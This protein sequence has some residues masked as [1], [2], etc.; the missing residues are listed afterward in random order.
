MTTPK[1]IENE[2]PFVNNSNEFI[3]ILAMEI[4]GSSQ[5]WLTSPSGTVFRLQEAATAP[6]YQFQM[7]F[8]A[9]GLIPPGYSLANPISFIGLQGSLEDLRG[10]L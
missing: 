3:L 10:Y 1:F 9:K 7:P 8:V 2:G 6:T 4:N 5:I